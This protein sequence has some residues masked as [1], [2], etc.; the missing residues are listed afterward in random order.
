[1]YWRYS[2]GQAKNKEIQEYMDK[3]GII[4]SVRGQVVEVYSESASLP[5][6]SEILTVEEDKSIKLEVFGYTGASLLCL[7]LT[8]SSSL[9]RGMSV[10]TTGSPILIPVGNEVL[11]RVMNIFG[12]EEDNKG[13]ILSA[14]R[15]PIYSTPP[16]FNLLKNS[17][18]ILETGIKAI[19]FL[20]PF[21][22]G[23]KVGFIGGAGVGKTVLI[24]ELI[25][26]ITRNH[27][28]VSVF[29][30][31]GERV[32]EGHELIHNLEEA[33]VLENISLIFGQ[34]GENA[35]VRLRVGDAAATIAEYF[36]DQENKDVLVF[37]DNIYRF[38][39]AGSE[40]STLIGDIPSEQ[41]YQ[42]DLQSA[43]GNLEERLVSTNNAYLTSIQTIY[44]PSDDI[45]DPGVYSIISYLDAVLVLSRSS[46]QV[47]IFP[48]IDLHQSSSS[49]LSSKSLLGE[50]H[51]EL[52]LKFK[53]IIEKYNQLSRIVAILGENEL[54]GEDHL[55]YNRAKKLINYLT[56]PFF[57]VE[58]Q[59]GRK[60]VFV[61]RQETIKDIKQIIEGKLDNISEDK[62][63]YIGSLK[64][65]SLI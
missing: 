44:V 35:A 43:L 48:P 53:Q 17:T 64:E 46:A 21:L 11:G 40:V 24:T 9:Y 55:I 39:Q 36:R 57:V 29:A 7:C 54:T 18:E 56:Q 5:E 59:T 2:L 33:K 26:N 52:I 22:K 63:L 10:L 16:P 8:N 23:S 12:E 20:T 6:I 25:H 1:M 45:T 50:E 19:D 41:G 32:R 15:L 13:A 65:I 61:P 28:G 27:Q 42:P 3:I 38:V 51:H 62:L 58:S 4:K 49:I 37:I 47:G 31:I 14:K 34:M 60:G 30:G